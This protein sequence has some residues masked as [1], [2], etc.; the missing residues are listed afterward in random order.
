MERGQ[1]LS[2]LNW[3]FNLEFNQVDLYMSQS[4]SFQDTYISSAFERIA[5]IEQSACGQYCR[6]N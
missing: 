3:F 1:I 6:E 5:Y 2:K 4:K